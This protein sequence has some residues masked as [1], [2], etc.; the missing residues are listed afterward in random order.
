MDAAS[1]W[2]RHAFEESPSGSEAQGL[3][4]GDAPPGPSDVGGGRV[5]GPLVA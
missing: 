4:G 5:I 3:D 2:R 1:G